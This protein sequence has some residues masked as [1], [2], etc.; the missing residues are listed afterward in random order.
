MSKSNKFT[1]LLIALLMLATG[2]VQTNAQ[3]SRTSNQELFKAYLSSQKDKNHWADADVAEWVVSD[4]YTDKST[5]LTHAYL[6]QMYNGVKVYNAI[7]VFAMKNGKI[8]YCKPGLIPHIKEKANGSKPNLSP[9][10]AINAA[11]K[12]LN[13]E[14]SGEFSQLEADLKANKYSFTPGNVAKLPIQVELVYMPTKNGVNLAWNVTMKMAKSHNWWN[15][16]VDALTG[17]FLDKN[18]YN[19]ECSFAPATPNYYPSNQ[20]QQAMEPSPSPSPSPVT[21]A[22]YK[23]FAFPLQAPNFGGRTV[24]TDPADP[25][26]SPYGWQDTDG[27]PGPEYTITRGNNVYAYEDQDADDLPGYSP[28][29]G[30]SLNFDYPFDDNVAPTVSMDAALTNLYYVNNSVHD[31]LYHLGFDENSGNFQSNNYG[32]GGI[33]ADYVLAEGFDG[34]GVDN[35]N[36]GTPPDGQNPR[37]QMYLWNIAPPDLCS[38]F[39][40][41]DPINIAGPMQFTTGD[42]EPPV[43]TIAT[44]EIV[45]VDDGN[46]N[47]ID[48]CE[49]ILNNVAGK[50]ALIRRG[51]CAFVQ[52]VQNAIDAGAIGVIIAN[53]PNTPIFHMSASYVINSNIPAIMISF[54]DFTTITNEMQNG[55][56]SGTINYCAPSPYQQKDG[57][58]DNGIIAHEYGHGVSNRLTGGPSNVGCLNNGEQGG[59]GWSDWNALMMTMKPGDQSTDAKGLGTYVFNETTNGVGIRSFPYSTDMSVNPHTYADLANNSEVHYIGEIWCSAIWD[60]SRFLVDAYG[61]DSNPLN[62]A[63]GNNLATILVLEGMKLQICGPGFLDSRDGILMADQLLYNGAHRCIIWNAFARRGMGFFAQEGDAN[64][65]GDET[66]DFSM[67]PGLTPYAFGGGSFCTPSEA[68]LDA[69]AGFDSYS[70]NNGE[71]TQ[72][73]VPT[74]F[75]TYTVTVTGMGCDNLPTTGTASATVSPSIVPDLSGPDGFCHGSAPFFGTLAVEATTKIYNISLSDLVQLGN[76]CNFGSQYNNCDTTSGGFSWDDIGSGA[77]TNIQVDFSVGIECDGTSTHTTMLNGNSGPSFAETPQYCDCNF[78]SNIVSLNIPVTGYVAGGSNTLMIGNNVTCFG[79]IPTPVLNNYYAKVTVTYANPIYSSYLWSTG[80]TTSSINYTISATQNYSVTVVAANGCIGVAS[81]DVI[82]DPLPTP[83]ITAL[84]PVDGMPISTTFCDN[85]GVLLDP[86]MYASYTWTGINTQ[87]YTT[88]FEFI[89]FYYSDNLTVVVTDGI[90][91]T[92]SATIDITAIPSPTPVITT[93]GPT[94][95]CQGD[96]ISLD[97]GT[98]DAYQWFDGEVTQSIIVGYSASAYVVVTDNASGC[99][100]MSNTLSIVMN[101]SPTPSII[102]NGPTEFCDGGSVMLDAGLYSSYLWNTGA[103]SESI[104]AYGSQPYEVTVTDA[105]GCT[106]MASQIVTVYSNPTPT[107]TGPST[108]CNNTPVTL[109]AGAY[110]SYIWSNNATSPTI[111]VGTAGT[112][113]VTV[114]D[115]HGCTGIAIRVI[116]SSIIQIPVITGSGPFTICSGSSITLSTTAYSTYHWST[117]GTTSSTTVSTAGTFMVTVANTFGCT[118]VGQRTVTVVPAPMPNISGTG[119]ATY[120]SGSPATLTVALYASYHWSNN[121]NT[122]STLIP[123]NTPGT[124]SV[125]VTN[126]AGC[127]G[128]AAIVLNNA[129]TMPTGFSTAG[130]TAT[131]AV[132]NWVQPGCYYGYIIRISKH[133]ANIWAPH[134][135]T[136]NT[137]YTF[138]QLTHNTQYDWQIETICNAAQTSVSGFSATQTFTTAPRLEDGETDNFDYAF[139]V[140]PNPAD[141]HANVAFTSDKEGVYTLRLMDVT[142]RLVFSASNTAVV[143]ENLYQM[144]LTDIAKGVYMVILQNGDAILQ[145]K[146]VVQ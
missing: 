117:G 2:F 41:T 123:V 27:Q 1:T 70:W 133:N 122:Q 109:N 99:T 89:T 80:E 139:N 87:P 34:G 97:A 35:A 56:V 77:V 134:S 18:D 63:A 103:T 114:T 138:S 130:I 121:A 22:S 17:N 54:D 112:Y 15:V 61:Y 86:G 55:S 116:N 36:F 104:P 107:I 91:C 65:A 127:T 8:G 131:T 50:I 69:G 33:G 118:A 90:G 140:Y 137:H 9:I 23:V 10:D 5:G 145:S 108:I 88:P 93:S 94:T 105:N 48:G 115:A 113:K 71:T 20:I 75:G 28:D 146:I 53:H 102:A 110:A 106:G 44:G 141:D 49:P 100:G 119:I 29:G 16:R 85:V 38:S 101:V 125:T 96:Y 111:S 39:N 78:N 14:S 13:V 6:N 144:N 62:V 120:C 82:D 40:V 128:T 92:G 59:E 45:L 74:S 129:C 19:K 31:H 3:G 135:I 42:F 142:G 7:T 83:S 72:T 12:H 60:M 68:T 30:V 136:P 124:Y 64:V 95:F 57:S 81:H 98:Y 76:S 46:G 37:M 126:A 32:R 143:G 51:T 58:V 79:L 47:V 4:Q 52:K 24:L 26:A 67:P 25:I 132:A 73:I 43:S 21:G 84:S 11:L 66:A